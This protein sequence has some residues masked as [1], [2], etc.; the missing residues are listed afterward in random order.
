MDEDNVKMQIALARLTQVVE[1][2][3]KAVDDRFETYYEQSRE[4]HRENV[5]RAEKLEGQA[6]HIYTEVRKTN[7][8]VTRLEEQIRT[9][10]ARE[11][12]LPS[13]ETSRS[14]SPEEAR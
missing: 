8:R 13:G 5:A 4:Q 3:F 1:S 14:I 7:G 6:E 12:P 10:Y 11:V 2:G 9:M